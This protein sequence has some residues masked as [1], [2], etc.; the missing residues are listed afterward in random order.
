MMALYETLLSADEFIVSTRKLLS[1]KYTQQISRK[2]DEHRLI[3]YSNVTMA[4]NVVTE[5]SS[6]SIKKGDKL[7]Q[8]IKSNFKSKNR[9]KL[10]SFIEVISHNVFGKPFNAETREKTNLATGQ[11]E[12]GPFQKL[13]DQ[14]MSVILKN[15]STSIASIVTNNTE[16]IVLG[17]SPNQNRSI[18]LYVRP[19]DDSTFLIFPKSEK[20]ANCTMLVV[21]YSKPGK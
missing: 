21:V 1:T 4:E 16:P 11:K 8:S 17:W 2:T 19:N 9:E 6:L 20:T 13:I 3:S 10:P 5:K 14:Y 12:S 7:K 18:P 15:S